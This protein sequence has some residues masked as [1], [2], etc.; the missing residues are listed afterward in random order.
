MVRTNQGGSVL[1][2]IIIGAVMVLLLAGGAYIV[3]QQS[4]RGTLT[5]APTQISKTPAPS[6]NKPATSTP[7]KP[8]DK[9]PQSAPTPQPSPAL[10]PQPVPSSPSTPATSQ[11][12]HTGPAETMSSLLAVGLLT[13]VSVAYLRSRRYSTL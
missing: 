7:Q 3:R 6:G 8:A 13:G 12:P 4:H 1:S 10:T 5:P 11:L 2:F 9:K